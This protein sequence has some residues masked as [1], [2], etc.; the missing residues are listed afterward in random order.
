MTAQS[1][2][3]GP[4]SPL[5]MPVWQ[6]DVLLKDH[7]NN[8]ITTGFVPSTFTFLICP[9]VIGGTFFTVPDFDG[10]T[11]TG[12]GS[13]DGTGIGKG[14]LT[15]IKTYIEGISDWDTLIAN[16]VSEFTPSTPIALDSFTVTYFMPLSFTGTDVTP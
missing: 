9:S 1:P 12:D 4:T 2:T 7:A 14:L 16:Y 8:P 13:A 15:A 10:E 5:A 6:V 11:P 3:F